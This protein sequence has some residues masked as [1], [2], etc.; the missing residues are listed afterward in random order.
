[1]LDMNI[2]AI[3][4]KFLFCE[5]L[6]GRTTADEIFKKVND[7]VV[8]NGLNWENCVGIC[9]DGAAAITG[10]HG[11]VVTRIK[12]VAPGA[13]FTH[14]SIHREALACKAMPATL[15]T[16]LDQSVKVVNFIKAR[17]LNSR[18]FSIICSE[19]GS[20]HNTLLLHTEVR[21]L[22]RGK[23]LSRLFELRSEVQIFLLESK[24]ETSHLLSDELWLMRLAYLADI[25]GKLNELNSSLQGRNI[26]PFTVND[27][28]NAMLKKL[29][30]SLS[31]LEQSCVASFSSLE[32]FIVKNELTLHVN[33]IED[34]KKHCSQLI[35]DFQFYFPEQFDD[36]EWIRNPFSD[37][38]LPADFSVQERDQF[39]ELS[40]DGGLKNEFK[41]DILCDFWLKQRAEYELIS[42][43]AI[44]FLI[45][46]STSYLVKLDFQLCLP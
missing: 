40:C 26:T 12:Q 20:E 30:F 5:S 46:F 38:I 11:G 9:S 41:K 21:W 43:K 27:K 15:K 7:F 31:D 6:S 13:K 17:A 3:E 14:C 2:Q 35:L 23:V 18:L 16:V 45:P 29:Q 22:S 8:S 33:L 1:M 32:S 42:D 36:K 44:Q 4:E 37:V 10:K 24:L 34:I 19:M 39:V 25:F 28:M